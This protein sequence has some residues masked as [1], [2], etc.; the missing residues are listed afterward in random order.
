MIVKTLIVLFVL[1]FDL[2]AI[3]KQVFLSSAEYAR[4]MIIY[5]LVHYYLVWL[6]KGE[7]C[8]YINLKR[9]YLPSNTISRWIYVYRVSSKYV[10]VLSVWN[11]GLRYFLSFWPDCTNFLLWWLFWWE[12]AEAYRNPSCW[13]IHDCQIIRHLIPISLLFG[14]IW[15][16]ERKM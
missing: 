4:E 14:D 5:N 11:F 7:H 10:T 13:N 8:F 3:L 2:T 12:P 15:S 16:F 6:L 9:C 1:I